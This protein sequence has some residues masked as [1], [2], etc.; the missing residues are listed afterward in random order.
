MQLEKLFKQRKGQFAIA[1]SQVFGVLFLTILIVAVGLALDGLG[2]TLTAGSAASN[3]TN[4]GLALIDNLT[5]QFPTIGILIGV[6]L[7]IAVVIVFFGPGISGAVTGGR[8]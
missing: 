3:A 2:S 7:L 5:D 6:G 4:D 8:R 1:N